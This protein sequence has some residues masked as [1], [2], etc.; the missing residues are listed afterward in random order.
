MVD[1]LSNASIGQG[2]KEKDN[3]PQLLLAD[4]RSVTNRGTLI[5]GSAPYYLGVLF[6]ES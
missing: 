6:C 2:R 3:T 1:D 5:S 4:M